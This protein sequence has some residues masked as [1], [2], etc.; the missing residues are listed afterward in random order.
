MSKFSDVD[1]VNRM[2]LFF[3]VMAF[4]LLTSCSNY[5][6]VPVEKC[7]EVV[8]HAKKILGSMAPDNASMM[9]DCKKASDSDRGCVM[10]ATKKGAVAQCM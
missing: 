10:A 6:P 9:A 2:T 8:K 3:T 5:D 4:V 1:G 7:A